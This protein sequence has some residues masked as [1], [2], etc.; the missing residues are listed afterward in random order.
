MVVSQL[1]AD[2]CMKINCK[3]IGKKQK[4][5][6]QHLQQYLQL[7]YNK[8]DYKLLLIHPVL[9]LLLSFLQH[10]QVLP[11]APPPPPPAAAVEAEGND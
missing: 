10:H 9:L 1:F 6:T 4:I 3:Q 2:D 5:N 7:P 11:V 8:N